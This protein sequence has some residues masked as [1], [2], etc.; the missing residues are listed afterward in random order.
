MMIYDD[1][2][3]EIAHG[4]RP[5]CVGERA[6]RGNCPLVYSDLCHRD[7]ELEQMLMTCGKLSNQAPSV[8]SR[9]NGSCSSST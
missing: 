8:Q 7:S 3:D 1:D 6:E 4:W 2:D 9:F 5:P